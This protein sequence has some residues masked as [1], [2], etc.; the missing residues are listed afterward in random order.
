MGE[1]VYIASLP[2]TYSEIPNIL[3]GQ[4]M[5]QDLP[6]DTTI[7][8]KFYNFNTGER[9]W[10]N[11]YLLTR[12]N[13]IEG[14]TNSYD[15]F[16]YIHSKY[17]QTFR[18]NGLCETIQTANNNGDLGVETELSDIALA[19]KFKSILEYKDCFGI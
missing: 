13:V 10:E 14:D 1:G 4:A 6:K 16:L 8:L 7:L 2:V 5:I 11:S 19:W 15:L 12:G 17:L 18:Y 9:Q 3:T